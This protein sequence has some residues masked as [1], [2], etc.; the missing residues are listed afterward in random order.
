MTNR[1]PSPE[2]Q[3]PL[4]AATF[5]I[6]MALADGE[7]IRLCKSQGAS[8]FDV[9]HGNDGSGAIG[10]RIARDR[11]RPEYVDDD[12]NAARGARAFHEIEENDLHPAPKPLVYT[13]DWNAASATALLPS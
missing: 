3:L 12:C 11:E 10:E 9:A 5:H 13:M 1:H 7:P 6:L 4:P 2:S 8:L